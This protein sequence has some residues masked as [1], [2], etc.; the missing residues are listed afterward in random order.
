MFMSRKNNF[1]LCVTILRLPQGYVREGKCWEW[2]NG[3]RGDGG[4]GFGPGAG[5]LW[6]DWA[7][8]GI[9]LLAGAGV[10]GCQGKGAG[11]K[12]PGLD[13]AG[14]TRWAQPQRQSRVTSVATHLAK[15][16]KSPTVSAWRRSSPQSGLAQKSPCKAGAKTTHISLCG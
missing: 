16:S 12:T 15:S 14:S 3:G 9:P 10:G 4:E 13:S 5:G 2:E 6:A 8:W 7:G 1:S 11:E